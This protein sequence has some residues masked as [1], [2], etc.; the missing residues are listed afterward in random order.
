MRL[1]QTGITKYE[2][3]FF[4]ILLLQSGFQG[5]GL[6]LYSTFSLTQRRIC[7]YFQDLPQ[8]EK[9]SAEK[10]KKFFLRSCHL[11]PLLRIYRCQR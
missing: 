6:F 3:I 7:P 11:F 2:E 8:R 10:K 9:V 5:P 4:G 1:S